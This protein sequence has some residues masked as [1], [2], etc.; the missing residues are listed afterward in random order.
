MCSLELQK[1]GESLK[2]RAQAISRG[3]GCLFRTGPERLGRRQGSWMAHGRDGSAASTELCP[4]SSWSGRAQSR[5]HPRGRQRRED[6]GDSVYGCLQ[7]GG[8]TAVQCRT[9]LHRLQSARSIPGTGRDTK[10][11]PILGAV[12]HGTEQAGPTRRLSLSSLP[13]LTCYCLFLLPTRLLS[14][15]L[16]KAS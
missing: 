3:T 15:Q 9:D 13:F 7:L 1:C 6:A 2:T 16:Y 14:F 10:S 5:P 11:H 8:A 12:L 4:H